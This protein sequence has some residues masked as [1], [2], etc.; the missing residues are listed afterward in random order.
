MNR[1][2]LGW[3]WPTLFFLALL[4]LWQAS[5]YLFGVEPFILPS[6]YV[7]G[8]KLVEQFDRLMM[9]TVQTLLE[10]VIGFGVACFGGFAIAAIT[11]HSRFFA[12]SLYPLL[13]I[14]QV[15]PTIAI[16]P[17]L[18]IWFGP[19]DVARLTVVFLIAF[20]PMVVNTTAGLLQVDEQLIELIRGLKGSRWKIFTRIRIPNSLPYVFTGMR[21]SIA[22]SVIGA[23]VAEFVAA[24]RGLGYVIFSGATN[25][26]T[27]LVFAAVVLLA[28]MGILLFQLVGVAQ[29]LAIPWADR[30]RAGEA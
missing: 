2:R 10:V 19:G 3:L 15:V 26:E 24:Q 7:I 29:R 23:V 30:V 11:A 12:R 18:V 9:H 1:D 21:I 8:V 20:F 14:S 17:L 16:A 13:V 6:P 25:L 22:L 5:G 28:A 4:G 27:D